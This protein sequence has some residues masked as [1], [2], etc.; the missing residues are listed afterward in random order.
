MSTAPTF[1]QVVEAFWDKVGIEPITLRLWGKY[2][3][4]LA[5][6]SE[7]NTQ[8]LEIKLYESSWR[9]ETTP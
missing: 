9:G 5:K 3:N 7:L 4:Y 6:S 2:T 1:S 8:I